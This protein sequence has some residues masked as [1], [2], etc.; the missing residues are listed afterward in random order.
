MPARCKHV[1]VALIIASAVPA[2]AAD[3]TWFGGNGDWNTQGNWIPA[4]V[5][6]VDDLAI[7]NAGA[8]TLTSAT[9]IAGLNQGGGSLLGAFDL[10]VTGASVWTAGTLSGTASTTFS[11]GLTISGMATKVLHGGRTLNLNGTTTW[12][13][14]TADNNNAIRFWNGG[15]LNN[16]GTFNDVNPF[17]SFIE[18]N[19]GSPHNF[20]NL[21]TYNKQSNAITTVDI[22]VAFNNSGTVNVNAGTFR[23]S[24]GTNSGAFN[25]ATGAV[26]DFRNGVNTL[27]SVS[28]GGTG[29]FQVSSD[30]VGADATVTLNGGSITAPFV[31]SGS[32]LAGTDHV[33]QAAATWTGGRIS[34]AA[35]TTFN[36]GL[37]I[38]GP[39]T[40]VIH[41][42]R[43]LELVGTTTWSGNTA[44]NNNRIQFWNGGTL[45]NR[46]TFNDANVHASFIEHSVGGPHNFNNIG[47]YNKQSNTITTVDGGVAFNN[48]G[49]V[50]VNAGILRPSGGTS[51]GV[52]NVASAALLE[53]VNGTNT[54]NNATI[55][56]A[57]TFRISSDSV[58]ADAIVILNGGTIT[59]PFVLAGSTLT[60]SD[61]VLQGPATWTGG[62]ISS[63]GN[64]TFANNVTISGASTKTI[65]GGRT[66]NLNAT[67]TWSGNTAGNNNAIRFWNGA[68][69]NNNGTFNDAN[70]FNA[71]IE[72][73][74]GGPHA[75]NNIGTYNKTQNTVT[76][77]DLG[78]TL[79]NVGTINVEAGTIHVASAITNQGLI[80]VAAGATF[81][82]NSSTFVNAGTLAGNGTI[83]THVNGDIANQGLISP[84]TAAAL[85]GHLTF[86]G[87][88]TQAAIGR[89]DIDLMNLASF[90]HLTITD[91]VTLRGT[92]VAKNAGYTPVVGD[93]F[94]V[95]V[96]DDR[97]ANSAFDA[98]TTSGYGA[99]V[100][101]DAIYDVTSVSLVVAAVPEPQ[102]YAL[103]LAGLALVVVARRR[104][105]R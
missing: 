62:A 86:D 58:G 105:K 51:N 78:V 28:I 41:G 34:G 22:G 26:L 52:F 14:N 83:A 55:A 100:R 31:M 68:T 47:T 69:L 71:F 43:T 81:R 66:V 20:N 13:G 17:A 30:N 45:N 29:T 80:N 12:T 57:G 63:A 91:D 8:A 54:L 56:G 10:T 73:N 104:A 40:K 4:F 21:G 33:F 49:T 32:V 101:F 75:F 87:D 98:V 35:T 7:I 77:F 84:G 27:N 53:F 42:G 46:G 76:T 82:G 72:H 25:I 9:T 79:N 36:A 64:T 1:L 89:V 70:T 16:N 60:G 74:V 99:G 5:P 39:N 93:R 24:G 59:T 61:H 103:M 95:M 92:I 6:G 90:D 65:V 18:H 94:V 3:R 88:L 38:S 50:N 11:N 85:I 37:A 23:P 96:F 2:F 67:T 19:V 102:T 48:T 97:L 15:T 44:D